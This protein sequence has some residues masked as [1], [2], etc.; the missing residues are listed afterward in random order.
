MA[1][2][3][4]AAVEIFDISSTREVLVRTRFSTSPDIAGFPIFKSESGELFDAF[5]GARLPPSSRSQRT[6]RLTLNS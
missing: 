4:V 2:L 5:L 3:R 1:I 6:R